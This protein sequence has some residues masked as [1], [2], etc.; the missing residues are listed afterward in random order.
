VAVGVSLGLDRDDRYR[1]VDDNLF[2]PE[3][4]AIVCSRQEKGSAAITCG[5]R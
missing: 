2:P 5:R 1:R 3:A 4:L